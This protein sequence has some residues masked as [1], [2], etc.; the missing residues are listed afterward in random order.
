MYL[1]CS[2]FAFC[3]TRNLGKH[4]PL[5]VLS[6]VSLSDDNVAV[7]CVLW[8]RC[9]K[10]VDVITEKGMPLLALTLTSWHHSQDTPGLSITCVLGKI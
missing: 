8:C 9:L 7:L 4:I 2:T 6:L 1:I 3:T 5:R 10:M